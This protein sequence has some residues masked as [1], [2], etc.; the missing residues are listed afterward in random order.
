[1]WRMVVTSLA[2]FESG[3]ASD[4]KLPDTLNSQA[5]SPNYN[6]LNEATLIRYLGSGTLFEGA[7]Q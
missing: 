7:L 1:M 6:T 4:S 3:S 2:W 5:A